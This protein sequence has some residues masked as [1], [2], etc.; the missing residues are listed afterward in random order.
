VRAVLVAPFAVLWVVLLAACA[1]VLWP[2]TRWT[3]LGQALACAMGRGILL[4]GGVRP[5]V[6]GLPRARGGP[7]VVVANHASML[8]ICT[9]FAV[10]PLRFLF[11]SRPFYFAV[12][13][14]GWAMLAQ[15]HLSLDPERPRRAAR[16]FARMRDRLRRG[17]SLVL[18]PEGSRSLD[19]TV[20]RYR[21]GPFLLA[22]E[23]G[24]P[25]LPVRLRG[26]FRALPPGAWRIAAGEVAVEIGEPI[27]TAGLARE[28]ARA[29]ALRVE[30]WTRGEG[31]GEGGAPPA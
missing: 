11:V 9:L 1:V 26:L 7:F 5:R 8:D 16:A 12:P 22:V 2:L 20:Q 19:G 29:L 27:A 24:V 6:T 21:R 14:L 28:D 23:V 3:G 31:G 15:G 13:F 18:F 25:V 4:L 30:E 17:T 10:L